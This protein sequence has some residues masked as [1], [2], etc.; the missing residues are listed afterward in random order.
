MR[1]PDRV[2][3]LG[4]SGVPRSRDCIPQ[5]RHYKEIGERGR[6]PRARPRAGARQIPTPTG[7]G[8]RPPPQSLAQAIRWARTSI[9]RTSL[10]AYASRPLRLRLGSAKVSYQSVQGSHVSP[11]VSQPMRT[12]AE[13]RA[14][15]RSR[16]ARSATPSTHSSPTFEPW[17]VIGTLILRPRRARRLP[18][19]ARGPLGRERRCP[20][21]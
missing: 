1:F 16:N 10:K 20:P 19:R 13:R 6:G 21:T 3:S 11:L 9:E 7:R 8:S 18:G 4:S 17:N 12:W 5:M 14:A 2:R 15:T